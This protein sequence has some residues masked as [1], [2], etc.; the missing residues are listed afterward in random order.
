MKSR[1]TADTRPFQ[2]VSKAPSTRKECEVMSNCSCVFIAVA[3]AAGQYPEIVKM[4]PH[5]PSYHVHP[6]PRGPRREGG[7]P[8]SRESRVRGFCKAAMLVAI[9]FTPNL[10]RAEQRPFSLEQI[11]S[12]PFPDDLTAAPAGGTVAWVFN[13]RGVRNI[14]VA[15]PPSYKARAIT[16]YAGDDGQEIGE[17]AWMPDGKGIVYTR[18]GDMEMGR[19]YPNPRSIPQGV[20]QDVWLITLAGGQPK[21]LGEGH[22]PVVSPKGGSVAFIY[23]E[24]GLAGQN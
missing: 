6:L 16:S 23:K 24:P 5:P 4:T 21:R 18:G 11:M 2:R 8:A 10:G 7:D 3:H 14:W 22:S 17:L 1:S 12:S 19:E 20:E 15:Q 9:L 13:A